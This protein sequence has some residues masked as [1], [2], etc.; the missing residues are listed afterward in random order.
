MGFG[1]ISVGGMTNNRRA[2]G[3]AMLRADHL[4]ATW[5]PA[6][7]AFVRGQPPDGG[8]AMA[9]E[10]ERLIALHDASNIA[11]VVIEPLAGSTGVLVPPGATCSACARSATATAC[12]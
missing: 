7:Q 5:D 9:D 10:L 12:C 1:G 4:R 8:A 3:G 2:F 6:T 11:G